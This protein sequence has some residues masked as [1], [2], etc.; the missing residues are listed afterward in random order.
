MSRLRWTIFISG[1]PGP[2]RR[3]LFKY[4]D[5][6][7]KDDDKAGGICTGTLVHFYNNGFTAMKDPEDA[8]IFCEFLNQYQP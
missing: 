2:D 5:P 1:K 7:D 4:N 3:Y 6:K 8:I